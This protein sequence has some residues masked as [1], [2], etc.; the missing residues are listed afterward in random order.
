VIIQ[1]INRSLVGLTLVAFLFSTIHAYGKNTSLDKAKKAYENLQYDKVTPLLK[2]A[3][4]AVESVNEEIEIYE[5]FALVHATYARK[6]AA[7]DAFIEVL[8]RA[9]NYRLSEDVS[10]KI[11]EVFAEAKNVYDGLPEKDKKLPPPG[12]ESTSSHQHA[13]NDAKHV[14]TTQQEQSPPPTKNANSEQEFLQPQEQ[15]SLQEEPSF[16]QRWWFWTGLGVVLGGVA[17][18]YFLQSYQQGLPEHDYAVRLQ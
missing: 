15:I 5:L 14:A 11:R 16:Y 3:L 1:V 13:K 6:D 8:K 17:T 18:I 4:K 7:R 2:R 10:P 9:E 12:A